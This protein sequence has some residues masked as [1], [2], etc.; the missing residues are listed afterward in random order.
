MLK[1]MLPEL[2]AATCVGFEELNDTHGKQEFNTQYDW[3][4]CSFFSPVFYFTT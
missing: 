2:V 1:K 3:N 4:K